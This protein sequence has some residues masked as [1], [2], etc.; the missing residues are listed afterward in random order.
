[1]AVVLSVVEQPEP[2]V[3]AE[4]HYAD[5]TKTINVRALYSARA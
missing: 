4:F 3:L 5:N 1:M 2:L